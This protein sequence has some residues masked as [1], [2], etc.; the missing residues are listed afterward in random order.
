MD[1]LTSFYFA[2]SHFPH[3]LRPTFASDAHS[4]PGQGSIAERATEREQISNTTVA[5]VR[6][7]ATSSNCMNTNRVTSKVVEP[8]LVIVLKLVR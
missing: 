1:L 8:I 3:A 5:R 2:K 7:N 4:R 6:T